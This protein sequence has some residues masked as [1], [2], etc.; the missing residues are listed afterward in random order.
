MQSQVVSTPTTYYSKD[1]LRFGESH[2]FLYKSKYLYTG[3]EFLCLDII[4]SMYIDTNNDDKIVILYDDRYNLRT[5]TLKILESLTY[6]N[7]D[8][9]TWLYNNLIEKKDSTPK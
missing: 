3:Y 9:Y 7:Y 8:L 4:I 5:V 6:C 1:C 2:I